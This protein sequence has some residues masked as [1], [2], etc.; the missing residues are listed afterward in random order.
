M[1]ALAKFRRKERP[2]SVSSCHARTDAIAGWDGEACRGQRLPSRSEPFDPSKTRQQPKSW[3]C[4][5]LVARHTLVEFPP[6]TLSRRYRPEAGIK[7][8]T[9]T[10][11]PYR[12]H[13]AM[14]ETMAG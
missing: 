2:R 14:K 1:R 12:A 5:P 4:A 11:T 3:S 6:R 8:V 13:Y 10:I 9:L 7:M